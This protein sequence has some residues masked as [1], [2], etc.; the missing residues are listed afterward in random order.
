[1]KL[2]T[3][4]LTLCGM[5]CAL[6]IV[7]AFIKIDIPL[8][9]YTM[10]F[11]LQWFFV[12]MAGLLLGAKLGAVS[13]TAYIILGL[14]GLPIFAAGGGPGYVFR[15]G[16][17]FLL[18]FVLAAFVIGLISARFKAGSYAG[19]LMA[20][21]VGLVIYYLVG[22]IYFYLIKNFYAG[23]P[24]AFGV[25]VVE[26]CLITVVPDFMLCMAACALAKKL[27]PVLGSAMVFMA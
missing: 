16:F 6:I 2:K 18:G 11:T 15:P 22:A 3:K 23:A 1:M 21:T 14:M 24:M 20:S 9:V 5:F 8:P 12:I 10:H 4:E 19:M 25:I 27:K 26:Y 7:G 13:V 17:G